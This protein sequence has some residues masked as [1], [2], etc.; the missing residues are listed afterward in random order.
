MLPNTG[1]YLTSCFCY[2][3]LKFSYNEKFC[4]LHVKKTEIKK[5]Q[6]YYTTRLT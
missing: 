5:L 2:K 6:M 3:V 4:T 1:S